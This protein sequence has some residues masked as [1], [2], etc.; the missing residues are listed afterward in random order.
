MGWSWSRD[1]TIECNDARECFAKTWSGYCTLLTKA[2][3][4]GDC[5]FCKPKIDSVAIKEPDSKPERNQKKIITKRELREYE[6]R[7]LVQMTNY[8][9]GLNLRDK[10]AM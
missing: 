9:M 1:K 5:P 10:E 7:K 3:D 4:E 6:E 8:S 2:Y